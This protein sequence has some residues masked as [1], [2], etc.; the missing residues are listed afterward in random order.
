VSPRRSY[1]RR[2]RRRRCPSPCHQHCRLSSPSSTRLKAQSRT[3]GR[4]LRR[5]KKTVAFEC[6]HP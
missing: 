2:A 3:V 4:P 6:A 1:R 5:K